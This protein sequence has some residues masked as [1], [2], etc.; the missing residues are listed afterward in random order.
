VAA[1]TALSEMAEAAGIDCAAHPHLM[2]P[3]SSVERIARLLDDVPSPRLK[4]LADPVNLVRPDDCFD[5]TALLDA[6]FDR[7]GERIVSIHA[8]DVVITG[9]VFDG[10]CRFTLC[11][12]DEAMPGKGCLDYAMFLRRA[13]ALD[14]NVIVNV[15]HLCSEDEIVVA[16]HFIRSVAANEGIRLA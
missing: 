11:H 14:R 12:L 3:L 16:F 10:R 7:L 6:M 5:T 8:K 15:E 9:A 2:G 1:T 4:V 13:D